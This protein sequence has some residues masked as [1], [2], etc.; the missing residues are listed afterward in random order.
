MPENSTMHVLAEHGLAKISGLN[1]HG[2]KL[3]TC[4]AYTFMIICNVQRAS[5]IRKN[6]VLCI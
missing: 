3:V 1:F 4:D 6:S 2:N 5:C